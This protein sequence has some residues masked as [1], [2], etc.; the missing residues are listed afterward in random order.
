MKF[1]ILIVLMT[2]FVGSAAELMPVPAQFVP[3]H[4]VVSAGSDAKHCADANA[5][6]SGRQILL[7]G[8]QSISLEK[9]DSSRPMDLATDKGCFEHVHSFSTG[10][11]ESTVITR[12]LS[13]VCPGA[14]KVGGTTEQWTI[15][16]RQIDLYES[17]L[18]ERAIVCHL[19]WVR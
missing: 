18:G 15:R 19:R 14:G 5:K 7:N 6:L 16:D 12:E 13:E 1:S 4:Y 3:G 9:E 17:D 11:S 8:F 2:P 10:D